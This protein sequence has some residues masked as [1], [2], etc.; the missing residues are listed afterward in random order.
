VEDEQFWRRLLTHGVGRRRPSGGAW[1]PA[2]IAFFLIRL[3]PAVVFLVH[4]Y[5]KLFGGHHDRTVALFLTV[6]IPLAE[7]VAWLVGALEM[8][9]GLALLTG[10][11]M[12]PLAFLLAIEM[13]VAILRVRLPQGLLGAWEFELTLLLICLGIAIRPRGID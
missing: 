12:R 1:T 10:I 8:A 5:L 11:L 9:G 2:R 7:A 6:N 4:G 13:A 3:A